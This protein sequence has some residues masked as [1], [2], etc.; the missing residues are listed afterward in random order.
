MRFRR[1]CR[2]QICNEPN[3]SCSDL[4]GVSPITGSPYPSRLAQGES[5]SRNCVAHGKHPRFPVSYPRY[6]SSA[7]VV[8]ISLLGFEISGASGRWSLWSPITVPR[9]MSWKPGDGGF[10]EPKN[11]YHASISSRIDAAQGLRIV[12]YFS[13]SSETVRSTFGSLYVSHF[14]KRCVF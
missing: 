3:C 2:L 12:R 7:G 5:C 4:C 11:L 10:F 14:Q 8:F 6:P 9:G 13:S 1:W